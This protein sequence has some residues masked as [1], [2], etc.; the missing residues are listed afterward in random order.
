MNS[1]VERQARQML[2]D[3]LESVA[4]GGCGCTTPGCIQGQAGYDSGQSGIVVGEPAHGRG[5]KL[6][7]L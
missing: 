7:D 5:V 1:F 2:G 6:D 3:T 4:Q